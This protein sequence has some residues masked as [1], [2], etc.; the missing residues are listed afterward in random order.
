MDDDGK[1]T[2]FTALILGES[3]IF[4]AKGQTKTHFFVEQGQ[5]FLF[6]VNWPLISMFT[7]YPSNTEVDWFLSPFKLNIEIA[8]SLEPLNEHAKH[9]SSLNIS[10]ANSL[11]CEK[12]FIVNLNNF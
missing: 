11:Q 4:E 7:K 5:V 6:G 2:R 3:Q 12:I 10:T 9:V 1:P 8:E